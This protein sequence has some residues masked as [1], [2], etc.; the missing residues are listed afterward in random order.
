[1]RQLRMAVVGAGSWVVASHLPVLA[2]RRDVVDFY[3]VCRL[4]APE[5]QRLQSDWGF[6]IAS[7]DYRE[8]LGG[9]PDIAVI[10]S[11]A[12]LHYEHAR[13]ALEAGAHVLVEKPFTIAAADARSLVDVAR[14]V[15]RRIVVSFG[16]NYRPIVQQTHDLLARIGGIGDIEYVSIEMSSVTRQLLAGAGAYPRADALLQPDRR[17][18]ADSS[19][20]GGGYAQAQLSHALGV[21]FWL[22]TL[23]ARSA[24]AVMSGVLGATVE[25][26]VAGTIRFDGGAIGSISGSSAH[27]GPPHRD[28]LTLTVVGSDGELRME[29]HNNLVR[30][31]R[32][33]SGT[34]Q[35]RL[36]ADA[37][38]YECDG[39]PNALVDLALGTARSSAS[40]GDVGMRTVEVLEALYTSARTN[41]EAAVVPPYADAS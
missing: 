29:F 33:D 1:M 15:D 36:P 16:Y 7:E 31:H 2:K 10:G 39:P 12:A 21:L 24:H 35:L 5:L 23:R 17:T 34:E 3:S 38:R 8:V 28:Y 32:P 18:W 26:Y 30:A 14:R 13:A 27:A 9:G 6:R 25:H 22:T 11:P 41:S 20:S 37:G 4:G 19:L 40:P